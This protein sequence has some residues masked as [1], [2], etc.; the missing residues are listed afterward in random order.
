MQSSI[1]DIDDVQMVKRIGQGGFGRVFEGK[2]KKRTVAVKMC[3]KNLLENLSHEIQILTSLPPHSNVITFYGVA[4][5]RDSVATYIITELAPNGS[6]YNYLHGKNEDV[7]KEEP[8]PDQSFAWALQVAS[9]INAASSPQQC[10]PLW[11]EE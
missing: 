1:I 7:K 10:G 3:L 5:S 11:P 4:L 6:L 2:W 8:S 9:G